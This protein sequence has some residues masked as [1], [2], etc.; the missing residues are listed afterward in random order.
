V[1]AAARAARVLRLADGRA[2][3]YAEWGDPDGRAVL[4]LHGNPGGR[5]LLWDEEVLRSSGV[6]WITVDRPAVGISDPL[7]G[8]GVAAWAL[9]VAALADALELDRFAVVGFSVG[10][11]YAAAC[12]HEL[13]DRVSAVA[14][15]AAIVPFD[16]PGTF[17]ALGRSGYWRLSRRAP[18]IAAL[19]LR[20]QSALARAL[21]GLATRAFARGVSDADR[22]LVGRR[23]EVVRRGIAQV[24]DAIRPGARGLVE[25]LLIVMRPW[26]FPL[27]EIATP[28]FVWQGDD[29]GSIPVEW[30]SRLADAIPGAELRLCHDEG[31]LLM[32]D[33]LAEICAALDVG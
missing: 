22:M 26:G 23:P 16:R 10:G 19:S 6:R 17:E 1:T 33:R 14:L 25:D 31:H 3:G 7:P 13:G 32:A 30:G 12:A 18:R 24:S 2:L 28:T 11:A 29:D 15:V 8:R 4:E 21:P 20:A 27:D 5:L 9:D